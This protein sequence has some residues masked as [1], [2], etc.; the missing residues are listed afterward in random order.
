MTNA[1][2]I[3]NSQNY[4]ERWWKK[5]EEEEDGEKEWGESIIC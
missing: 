4:P 2:G 5:E 3:I 1:F